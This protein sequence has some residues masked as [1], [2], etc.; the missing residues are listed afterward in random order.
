MIKFLKWLLS[1]LEKPEKQQS[2]GEGKKPEIRWGI[3]IPHTFKGKGAYSANKKHNE[4]DYASQMADLINHI[5]HRFRDSGGV[6]GACESLKL[7]DC[8]ASLEPHLNAYNNKAQ[9]YEILVLKG[10][11]RSKRVAE[12]ILEQFGEKYPDRRN[13]GVKEIEKGDRGYWNLK[14]AK[15]YM[16][17]ALL[18]EMFFIDNPDEWITPAEM[19]KFWKE[20]LV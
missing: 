17:I 19:A 11:S 8:N 16:D 14:T 13:R 6:K 15:N 18:S 20:V 12:L 9:G 1:L 4:Y 2:H 7:N 10:D 5:P 3:I